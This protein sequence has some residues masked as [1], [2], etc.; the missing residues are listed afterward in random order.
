MDFAIQLISLISSIIAVY[1][2]FSENSQKRL[3]GA[4][5]GLIVATPINLFLTYDGAWSVFLLTV[6]C[7][8]IYIKTIF[9]NIMQKKEL[10][11]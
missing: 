10:F 6:V 9:G 1:L 5:I 11:L 8:L 4:Y 3:F 2:G 7:G